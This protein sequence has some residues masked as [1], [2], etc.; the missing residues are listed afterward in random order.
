MRNGPSD[1]QIAQGQV[2]LHVADSGRSATIFLNRP[3]KRNAL[4]PDMVKALHASLE[5]TG[6]LKIPMVILRSAA[7][8]V[9]CA[10]FD[11]N[12]LGTEHE[13]RGEALLHACSALLE[14]M[15]AITIAVA[16]G[17]VAG[18][19]MELFMACDLRVATPASTF[20]MPPVRLARAYYLEGTARFVRKLGASTTMDMLVT[21][22]RFGAEEASSVGIV[23]RLVPDLNAAEAYCDEARGLPA[24]AQQG[25]KATLRYVTD[26]SV[27]ADPEALSRLHALHTAAEAS[28]DAAEAASAFLEKRKPNYTGA[29]SP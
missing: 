29:R 1:D 14:R 26:E 8:G 21:N 17:P 23:T 22:R 15:E 24:L 12:F 6:D 13:A 11:I 4:S 2:T 9:F 10:G 20:Q 18:G 7:P 19:G 3:E 16:D 27:R 28:R 25:I 5:R